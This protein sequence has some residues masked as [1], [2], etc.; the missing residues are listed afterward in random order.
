MVLNPGMKK[1]P[2]EMSLLQLSMYEYGYECMGSKEAQFCVWKKT[3]KLWK[4]NCF[5]PLWNK[6]HNIILSVNL[7]NDKMRDETL[8]QCCGWY[9]PECINSELGSERSYNG[10]CIPHCP[11]GGVVRYLI[12]IRMGAGP[13]GMRSVGIM[14]NFKL[15]IRGGEMQIISEK[16]MDGIS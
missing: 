2:I 4:M 6:R 5:A 3:W 14:R 11:G 8:G 16:I 15:E 10:C 13:T 1:W 7:K 12:R 9:P